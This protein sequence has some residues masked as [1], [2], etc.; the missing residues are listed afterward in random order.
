[1]GTPDAHPRPALTREERRMGT[2][3]SLLDK[4]GGLD[5][6]VGKLESSG[7]GAKAKSWVGVGPNESIGADDVKRALGAELEQVA[8]K[9]GISKDDA[10]DEVAQKLPDTV[11]KA[12]PN[13]SLPGGQGASNA[14][15][16]DTSSA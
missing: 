15:G 8:Q 14:A 7:L 6:L 4:V 16:A 5:G 9:L 12:T 2:V 1:M 10:A 11:D 13:G 3:D